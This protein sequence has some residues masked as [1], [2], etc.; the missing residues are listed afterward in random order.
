MLLSGDVVNS[1]ND[2]LL[3]DNQ[4]ENDSHKSNSKRKSRSKRSFLQR[5]QTNQN[6]TK[7]FYVSEDHSSK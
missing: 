6:I 2:D 5:N 4:N 7:P 1:L 3:H